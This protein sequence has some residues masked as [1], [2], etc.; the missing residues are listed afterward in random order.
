MVLKCMAL[1]GFVRFLLSGF[2]VVEMVSMMVP[3]CF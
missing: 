3:L 2:T 1:N